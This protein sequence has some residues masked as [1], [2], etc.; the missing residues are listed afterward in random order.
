MLFASHPLADMMQPKCTITDLGLDIHANRICSGPEIQA[1]PRY[2]SL[3]MRMS[4]KPFGN[5]HIMFNS[6]IIGI[7]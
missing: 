6:Y 7:L 3:T 2:M 5:Q 1:S 4:I